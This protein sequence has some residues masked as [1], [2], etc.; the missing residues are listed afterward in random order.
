MMT[1]FLDLAASKKLMALSCQYGH[2][3]MGLP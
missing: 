2:A 1:H 3:W